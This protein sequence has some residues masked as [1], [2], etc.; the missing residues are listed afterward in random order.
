[1]I[2]EATFL[3]KITA[4]IGAAAV[5]LI[6]ENYK[7]HNIDLQP[8][9]KTCAKLGIESPEAALKL[10][11]NSGT[12][13]INSIWANIKRAAILNQI[14]FFNHLCDVLKKLDEY[15]DFVG[16]SKNLFGRKASY[17][18]RAFGNT[19]IVT[20]G[21]SIMFLLSQIQELYGRNKGQERADAF[22]ALDSLE[23]VKE[24]LLVS[25]GIGHDRCRGASRR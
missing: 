16:A 14:D 10:I 24:E 25:K 23:E 1:M 7:A 15:Q 19:T 17:L 13:S 21:E 12:L 22:G 4:L 5:F 2:I 18:D 20:P 11:Y 9:E 6:A 8:Y 3:I